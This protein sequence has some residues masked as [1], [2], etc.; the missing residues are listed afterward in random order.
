MH[1]DAGGLGLGAVLCKTS[2]DGLDRVIA[3]ASQTERNYPAHKLE[4]LALKWAVMDQFHEYLSG[5]NFDIYTDNPLMYILTSVKW[6]AVG[7]CWI[8]ALANDNFQFHNKTG[9]SDVEADALSPIPW[10]KADLECTDGQTVKAIIAGCTAETSFFEAYSG[11]SVLAKEFQVIF[12]Q[13]DTLFLGKVEADQ[14]PPLP[15]K[16]G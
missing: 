5:G 6:D 7:Q 14:T 13:E 4:F 8:A 10:Q 9:K 11:K 1:T 2:E 16:N 12:S 15:N 3:Y